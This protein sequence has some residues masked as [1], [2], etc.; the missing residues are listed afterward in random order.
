MSQT[1][2]VVVPC[3]NERET[4][5]ACLLALRDQQTRPAK[6]IVVDNGSTDGSQQLA[7]GLAEVVELPDV[8]ISHLRNH[9][10]Y[11]LGD[12]D[13]VGFV[14]ADVV[15]G[16]GWLAAGLAAMAD[17]AD[18][19]GSRSLPHEDATWVAARW[20][21]VERHRA[22][23]AS[24]LWSQHLLVR[25][26]VLTALGGF[27]EAMRTGEDADLSARA[28]SLGFDVRLV[29]TMTAAHHG[30]APSLRGFLR[31]EIWHTST[32]GWY[33]RMAPSSRRLVDLTAGW[34]VVG[35]AAAVIAGLAR[36][37]GPL[38]WW[39][40]GSAA[41]VAA[42]GRVAGGTFRHSL[43]DG[44]LLSLWSLVRVGRLLQRDSSTARVSR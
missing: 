30:F 32:P 19:V 34:M 8:S 5:R 33:A 13:I 29:P 31:R 11:R 9:G 26:H 42:L 18:V 20:A 1:I 12:V 17:G 6:I 27:D 35:S 14:D 21:Q 2:G 36:R 4:L 40:A 3:K 10:A 24:L 15:V 39:V 41:G 28:R 43:D 44:V 16:P 7:A 25:R 38:L 37:P 22:H 23:D